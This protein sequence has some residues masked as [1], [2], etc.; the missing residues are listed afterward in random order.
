LNTYPKILLT[1]LPLV[2]LLIATTV[3]TTYYFS[4][5]ALTGLAETWLDTRLSEALKVV[6]EQNDM[7]YR[8]G[9]EKIQAS[10]RKAQID[11]GIALSEIEVGERGFIFAISEDGHIAIH[12]DTENVGMDVSQTSWFKSLKPL[13]NRLIHSTPTG[14]NLAMADFFQPWQ[15]YIVAS[16]PKPEVYG[17]A[18]RMI[19]W[20]AVLGGGGFFVMAVVLMFLARRFT[21]PLRLLAEKAQRIGDGHL[22][23]RIPITS[24]D[25]FGTLARM[26]N[27]MVRQLQKSRQRLEERVAERTAELFNANTRL[28]K[29]IEERKQISKENEK[30]QNQIL[31]ARK[32]KAVATLAGGIAHDFNNLLMGIQGNVDV[33]ALDMG[34]NENHKKQIETIYGCVKSGSR[35]TQQLLGFARLGKYET[36]VSD[37]NRLIEDS[38]GLVDLEKTAVMVTTDVQKDIWQVKIDRE[39]ILQVLEGIV[40]NAVQAMPEGG[41]IHLESANV[42]MDDRLAALRGVSTGKYVRVSIS[43]TGTGMEDGMIEQ[44]FDP[45]FT[46][47]QMQRGTGL[48]LASA[49]GIVRNHGGHIDVKSTVNQG[50]TFDI[51]LRVHEEEEKVPSS[52]AYCKGDGVILL[53]DDDPM[54]LEVGQ[55]M[56]RKLGYSVFTAKGGKEAISHYRDNHKRISLVILDMIMP[57]VGGGEAFDSIKTINPHALVLLA[58]GYSYEGEAA[59]IM[60]R[61]CSGFIQKPYSLQLLSEKVNAIMKNDG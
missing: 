16:D 4:R 52:K 31:Q 37:P 33:M 18:N 23:T 44:I 46:T 47:K 34:G 59:E 21:E 55:A 7:L 28:M 35:L 5:K 3:G 6:E 42:Q 48:G 15:W 51:Y 41:K 54:I 53:V 40:D 17:V 12:P 39:Q 2:F 22:E 10:I 9:L 43:D 24:R 32:M 50:T 61:G 57:G 25:E 8:Y 20:M 1:I 49:Y 26:F 29:E 56:L 38:V 58:S 60:N 13:R 11:A 14:D 30:L 27:R 19:P 45:F 36:E